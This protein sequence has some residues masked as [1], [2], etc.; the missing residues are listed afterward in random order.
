MDEISSFFLKQ[1][2]TLFKKNAVIFNPHIAHNKL[3]LIYD[4]MV[5]FTSHEPLDEK[6]IVAIYNRDQIFPLREVFSPASREYYYIALSNVIAYEVTHQKFL[7][8]ID[9]NPAFSKEIMKHIASQ[10]AEYEDRSNILS[11]RNNYLRLISRLLFLAERFGKEE[12]GQVFIHVPMTQEQIAQSTSM[13][14][15]TI[16]KHLKTLESRK[17]VIYKHNLITVLNL[18]LLQEELAKVY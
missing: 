5:G 17:L 12:H 10:L 11:I 3:F 1:K 16:I 18:K 2:K 15:E 13:S 7:E 8:E 4:G 6:K 14:R 9:L